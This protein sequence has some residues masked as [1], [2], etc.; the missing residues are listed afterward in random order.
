MVGF[1][2]C[3]YLFALGFTLNIASQLT[4]TQGCINRGGATSS[5]VNTI[6][7]PR[8]FGGNALG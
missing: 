2:P 5:K 6:E 1:F 3:Q 8:G 4:E 7:I